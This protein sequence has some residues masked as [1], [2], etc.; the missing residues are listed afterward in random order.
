MTQPIIVHHL[1]NSRSQ[2]ILWFLEELGV[3]YEVRRHARDPKTMLAP[4]ELRKLHPLG[5]SPIIEDGGRVYAETG[6]ILEHLAEA[7]G[8]AD[9]W[10]S[11]V[12]A[13][14]RCRYWLHYAEG[15]LMPL[16]LLKLVFQRMTEPPVPWALR[17]L[18][19]GIAKTFDKAFLDEQLSLHSDFVCGE[20]SRSTWFA[21]ET[22]SLADIQMSF[23]LEAGATRVP[24]LADR[25]QITRFL[26]QVKTRPAYQR[27]LERGGP[28]AY[29]HPA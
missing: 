28:Y 23:P 1:E 11:E 13:R 10:P 19:A 24:Q 27:A 17:L 5:K 15:S 3:E 20:L 6:A 12:E 29:A 4:P 21:G 7:H 9:F 2:R 14:E 18:T 22:L 16:L 8:G 26:R 25:M